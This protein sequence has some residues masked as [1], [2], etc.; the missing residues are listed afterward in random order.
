MRSTWFAA[1]LHVVLAADYDEVHGQMRLCKHRLRHS[2]ILIPQHSHL[3]PNQEAYLIETWSGSAVHMWHRRLII[4]LQTMK[5]LQLPE[6]D[7]GLLTADKAA[8]RIH[9]TFM[10]AALQPEKLAERMRSAGAKRIVGFRPTGE[11][12]PHFDGCD[13]IE[14]SLPLA[15]DCK[16]TP[17]ACRCLSIS[18]LQIIRHVP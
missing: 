1:A 2:A 4:C 17:T 16:H 6:A 15:V 3:V 9:V 8:A 12:T 14:G 5:M 13:S 18:F 11:G 10:G 7:M